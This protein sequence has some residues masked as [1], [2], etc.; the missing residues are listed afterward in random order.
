MVSDDQA[1]LLLSLYNTETLLFS[2]KL[3]LF[4]LPIMYPHCPYGGQVIQAV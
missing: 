3:P 2:W 4:L 1:F